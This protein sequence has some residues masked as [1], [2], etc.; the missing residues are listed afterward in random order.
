MSATGGVWLVS[1]RLVLR[2][3][4][5]TDEEAVHSFASD[6]LV[7]RYTDWGPNSIDDTRAFLAE[8]IR[9]ATDPERVD[10]SLAA[11]HATSGKL[12]GSAAIAVT[13]VQHK[14][15]QVGFVF[16]RDFWPQQP[17]GRGRHHTT[18]V[19]VQ[20]FG[21]ESLLHGCD[22]CT[23]RCQRQMRALGSLCDAALID[24]LQE[25][26]QIGEVVGHR[27]TVLKPVQEHQ[28]SA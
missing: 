2:A 25:Q 13:T 3:F 24:Y 16:H 22:P 27:V 10:F 4:V 17:P 21:P 1:N 12:I 28:P 26:L 15:A 18:P 9:Q 6:P 19:A 8:A 5:A 11:V 23:G 14:R 7:T 20:Q